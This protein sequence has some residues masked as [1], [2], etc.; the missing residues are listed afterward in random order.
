MIEFRGHGGVW[1]KLDSI[2]EIFYNLNDFVK[3]TG[4]CLGSWFISSVV[5]A[6]LWGPWVQPRRILVPEQCHGH[7]TRGDLGD[8]SYQLLLDGKICEEVTLVHCFEQLLTSKCFILDD[9]FLTKRQLKKNPPRLQGRVWSRVIALESQLCNK[10]FIGL[11]KQRVAAS[12][13]LPL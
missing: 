2:L 3:N 5:M 7:K 12:Q 8:Q 13:S 10:W 9:A 1:S 6:K 4:T 11:A